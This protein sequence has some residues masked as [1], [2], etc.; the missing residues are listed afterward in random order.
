[1]EAFAIVG[2]LLLTLYAMSGRPAPSAPSVV[3]MANPPQ[4]ESSGSSGAILLLLVLLV[5][6]MLLTPHT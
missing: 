4:A 6:W 5:T 3:V 2:L 1:M